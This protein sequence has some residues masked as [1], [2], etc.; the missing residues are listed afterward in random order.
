[1]PDP[2]SGG[3]APREPMTELW[4]AWEAVAE[5]IGCPDCGEQYCPACEAPYQRMDK[6][7][8]AV[9]SPSRGTPSEGLDWNV[10]HTWRRALEQA[11]DLDQINQPDL[12]EVRARERALTAAIQAVE[13]EVNRA[14]A[15]AALAQP[16]E[17]VTD[18]D[19]LREVGWQPGDDPPPAEM[20]CAAKVRLLESAL[21]AA[22]GG[23]TGEREA[24]LEEAA[25]IAELFIGSGS[26][27]RDDYAR[28][29][30]S[31]VR[32]AAPAPPED[33]DHDR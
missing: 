8:R 27:E 30:A 12:G 5:R 20:W 19:V 18:A 2:V 6:A 24:A 32:R 10:L 26:E 16:S 31:A 9:A 33:A 1:M 25:R 13:A 14:A 17:A 23:G 15:L 22:S 21:R 29:I 11:R 3:P 7:L 4:A 28:V